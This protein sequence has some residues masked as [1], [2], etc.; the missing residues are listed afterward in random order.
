M[1]HP[2]SLILECRT[3][4]RTSEPR[5]MHGYRHD[6]AC[7][8]RLPYSKLQAVQSE[9]YTRDALVGVTK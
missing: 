5:N 8:T 1:Q 3:G 9:S 6:S 7:S 4:R 2:L